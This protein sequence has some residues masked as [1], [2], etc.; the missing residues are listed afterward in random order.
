MMPM[1]FLSFLVVQPHL[2]STSFQL[3]SPHALRCFHGHEHPQ[4]MSQGRLEAEERFNLLR[5]DTYRLAE[6]AFRARFPDI[7]LSDITP[8]AAALADGWLASSRPSHQ[9]GWSWARE[10]RRFRCHPRRVELAI[11]EGKCLLCALSL[12]KVSKG[13]ISAT[14]HLLQANPD[15]SQSFRGEVGEMVVEY[16]R[17]YALASHCKTM[18]IDSPVIQL[19]DFYKDLGFLNE[20]KKGGRVKRLWQTV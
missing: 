3:V 15:R 13:R 7:R 6:D 12:G 20:I 9:I 2:T 18:V 16:L 17:I 11:W 4:D 8:E 19:I 1:V 10:R 5:A 14:V